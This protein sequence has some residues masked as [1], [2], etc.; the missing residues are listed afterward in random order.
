MSE[1]EKQCQEEAMRQIESWKPRMKFCVLPWSNRVSSTYGLSF[2]CN[3]L[4][5]AEGFISE[6][7]TIM[8]SCFIQRNKP[9]L[10][11][12]MFSLSSFLCC[13]CDTLHS[14]ISLNDESQTN[15]PYPNP[16]SSILSLFPYSPFYMTLLF[17]H[18]NQS[19]HNPNLHQLLLLQTIPHSSEWYK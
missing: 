14:I 2:C 5:F 17:S 16:I 1:A 7:C 3:Q 12:P 18:I 15:Y 9:C 10:F 6:N 11:F 13:M 8:Y 4:A 19:Y